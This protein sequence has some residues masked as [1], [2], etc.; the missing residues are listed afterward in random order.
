M[1]TSNK[2][3]YKNLHKI[4]T[5]ED[6][7]IYTGFVKIENRDQYL[8]KAP[9]YQVGDPRRAVFWSRETKRCV[10][11]K[12]GKMFGGYRY[13]RGPTYFYG[14]YFLLQETDRQKRTYYIKPN[15]D[16]LEWTISYYIGVCRGFSGFEKDTKYTC[17]TDVKEHLE[18]PT[19]LYTEDYLRKFYPSA[20]HNGKLKEYVDAYD[21]ISRLHPKPLGRALYENQTHNGQVAGSR[22]GGKSYIFAGEFE[23]SLLFDG[24]NEYNQEFIDNKLIAELCLGS[25]DAE[26]SSEFFSKIVASINAKVD[27]DLSKKYNL[28]VA[29]ERVYIDGREQEI[30]HP[31]PLYRDFIGSTSTGNKTNPFRY[32]YEELVN[33]RWVPTGGTGTKLNHVN[34]SDKKTEGA[35]AGSGG[36][37]VLS[38]IE[39]GGLLEK[40][41]EVNRA[42]DSTVAREGVRFGSE[43]YIGTS[44][45]L[46]KVM[47]FRKMMENPQDYSIYP[48][49]NWY[50]SE[51]KDGKVGFFL[52]FYMTLRQFK[53]ENGN[54][55]FERAA[56][57]V[58]AIR[59]QKAKSSDPEA[60]RKEK[61]N[62]P[63]W[64]EEMW[65]SLDGNIMPYAELDAREKQLTKLNSYQFLEK[66]V[67][68]IWDNKE[69]NGVRYK[70]D[71]SLEPFR[72]FPINNSRRKSPHGC[73]V[74]Y[75][76]PMYVNG[77]IPDDMYSFVGHDPYVE[78]DINRG[79]SIGSTYVLM[80]PKYTEGGA[81]GNTIVAAYNDKPLQ[82]LDKYYENQSKLLALYGNPTRGLWFEKNRG[83]HCRGYYVAKHK[84][85][86]LAPTP[87]WTQG[88]RVYA[89]K[90]SSYG[91]NV[92]SRLRKI[93]LAKT[94]A[95]WLMEETTLSDGTKRNVER[96]PDLF[97]IRQ[98]KS[99]NLDDNF[100]A[101]DGF[102]G[103]IVGLR[104]Y[105]R[106]VENEI[107][108]RDG[109]EERQV[110]K[111]YL[112][113][114][115]I[116]KQR[117]R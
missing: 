110:L 61:M 94:M 75:D 8:T 62:R 74:L 37:Y 81:K 49:D 63:C 35:Q 52:P 43:F 106:R 83:D 64:I 112:K 72:D 82:G 70:L 31:C 116:F 47:G 90:I 104:E 28:G 89:Q 105:Q 16:D 79:G 26:K 39:E 88:S 80:N 2:K 46:M 73:V 22:G 41:T 85:N 99:Y 98:L 65:L 38:L 60:L 97:L 84:N 92:G 5:I 1:T 14:N 12:W 93:E 53:D 21:Y 109:R 57:Y 102:R 86:L 33:G 44:G 18:D 25:G 115:R 32:V 9:D 3:K 13:M 59:A 100:D 101:V 10:E 11:G 19:G 4:V 48:L 40:I 69:P 7:E 91:Y 67:Q 114:D 51:G 56:M 34:Y 111:F 17:L 117:N 36:R 66:K 95:D 55:D 108:T 71:D 54:T 103:C 42:N 15:I 30:I 78:E 6:R 50:G 113:N 58:E 27:V 96:L 29:T 68:L 45:N 87:Q 23:H 20:F 77:E 24:A 107:T 76:L